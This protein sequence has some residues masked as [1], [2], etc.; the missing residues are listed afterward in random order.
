MINEYFYLAAKN[1]RRRKLRSWLTIIG[2]VISIATIFLLISISLG[3]DS[4]VKEQFRQLGTDK[5]FILPKGSLG[6]P[7]TSGAVTLTDKDVSAIKRI[8]GVKDVFYMS[9]GNAK[10]EYVSQTRY[11]MVAGTPLDA[12][13]NAFEESGFLKIDEGRVL[14]QGDSGQIMVGSQYKLNSVFK[15]PVHAGDT[16]KINGENFRVKAVLQTV[17][18]P[19]DDKNIYMPMSDFETLFPA[20]KNIYDE[21]IVQAQSGI[22]IDDLA[23]KIDKQLVRTRDVTE[24]TK[25]FTIQTPE[26]LLATFGTILNVLTGFLLGIAAISLLVGGIGIMNTMYTAVIERTKEIGVMKAVGARNSDVL[27]IFTIESGLIGTIG[28]AGGIIIGYI[29]GKL[30]EFVVTTQFD[31]KLLQ[32]VTPWYLIVGCLLFSF[33]V[34]AVAGIV[35]ARQASKIKP[36]VAL[37]YE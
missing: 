25:D 33:I 32:I 16:L 35:P 15:Q 8:G 11:A 22:I 28:G 10:L 30:I 2:I 1:I 4:A 23:N 21:L 29:F 12:S 7:G 3:L 17:G 5:L 27:K 19:Q 34:G 26:E 18:N 36:V 6:G 37:R 20:K 31:T 9:I 14:S 13:F 24:K